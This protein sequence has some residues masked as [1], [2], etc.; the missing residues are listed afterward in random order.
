MVNCEHLGTYAVSSMAENDNVSNYLSRYDRW[1]VLL[2]DYVDRCWQ[3]TPTVPLP[4][5][6]FQARDN[7]VPISIYIPGIKL[8]IHIRVLF[9]FF[10]FFQYF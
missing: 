7:Y 3:G 8:Q 4:Q 5:H 9:F 10:C 1:M 6:V 2:Q